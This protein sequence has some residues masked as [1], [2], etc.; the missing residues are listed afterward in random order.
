MLDLKDLETEYWHM[1]WYY[2][3]FTHE[4]H[5]KWSDFLTLVA[6]DFNYRPLTVRFN[7][8]Q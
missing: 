3:F 8:P 7:D 6:Y 5:C 1:E 4:F 2:V